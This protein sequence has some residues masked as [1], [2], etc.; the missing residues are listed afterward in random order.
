MTYRVYD[1]DCIDKNGKKSELHF[2]N[3][4][5]VMKVAPDVS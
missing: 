2:E 1:Y 5:Q 3:A 4:V